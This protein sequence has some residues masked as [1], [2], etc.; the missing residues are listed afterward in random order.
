MMIVDNSSDQL[1]PGSGDNNLD[2]HFDFENGNKNVNVGEM[3][4]LSI[5]ESPD[6][7][8]NHQTD[9]DQASFQ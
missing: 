6:D 3:H 7:R 8:L 4:Y 5:S 1:M 2:E 9:G